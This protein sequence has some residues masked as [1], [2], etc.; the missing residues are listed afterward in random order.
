MGFLTPSGKMPG[1][2]RILSS[3]SAM[4]R[5]IGGLDAETVRY[6]TKTPQPIELAATGLLILVAIYF[7]G[8]S[9]N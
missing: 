6:R 8:Q 5:Y 2:F 1:Y 9:V 7:P 3:S 4:Q